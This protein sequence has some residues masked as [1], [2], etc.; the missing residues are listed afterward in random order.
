MVETKGETS[1]L[2]YLD[3][4][5]IQVFISYGIRVKARDILSKDGYFRL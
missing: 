5:P 3:F 4:T 1:I 2:N